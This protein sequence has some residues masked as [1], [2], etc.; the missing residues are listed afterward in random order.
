MNKRSLAL[1]MV[2]VL[3]ALS[4]L[5]PFTARAEQ[6]ATDKKLIYDE[7]DTLYLEYNEALNALSNEYGEKRETDFIVFTTD[8]PEDEDVVKLTEDF[9]DE[10]APGYDKPHGNAVILTLDMRNRDLYLAGFY[11]AED[12]LDDG[13][14]DKIR[15]KIAPLLSAGDY[16]GAFEEYIRTAYRYMGF[17]PGVNPDSILF[18]TWFQLGSALVFGALV[19]GGMTFGTGGRVTVNSRT[20][21]DSANSGIIWREDN[22]L[23]TTVTKTKIESSS[24][25]GS[26]GGGGGGGG[27]TT[28]GGHSHSGSRGSF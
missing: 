4:L 7:A 1:S 15:N 9:Y 6:T 13:R 16:K 20:Y 5:A 19:V 11:K 28:G 18:N 26:S 2:L 12:Y 10:R 14:L 24:S 27:G 22:Y 17:R 25:S 23:R 3:I 8:N 21:E